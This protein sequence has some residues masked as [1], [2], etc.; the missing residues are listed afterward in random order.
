MKYLYISISAA[1]FHLSSF[2]FGQVVINV[3]A[4][5]LKKP[6]SPYIYGKNNSLSDNPA[7]PLNSAEWQR[8]HDMG[9]KMFRENGG[10]NATKYN[11]RRKLSSHPDWY[12][13]VY[14]H[15]WDFAASSLGTNIPSAQGMWAFQLIGKAARTST[16]NFND[17][18]F[19]QSKWWSGTGQNL[20]GGGQVDTSG[21]SDALVEGNPSLYLE[22]WNADSTTGI[23][24]HWFGASGPGLDSGKLVYWSMDNE[25][26]IWNGTHD[27]VWPSQPSAEEFMQMYFATAKKARAKFPGIKLVGPVPANEWQWYNWNGGKINYHG[28]E[29]VWLEYFILRVAEEQHTSGIRLL[30]VLDIHF[31]PYETSP[32]DITQLYRVFFDTTYNYP[33]ANGVKKLGTTITKEYIFKRCSDWLKQYMG[34]GH[35]VTFSVTETAIAKKDDPSLTA[36]WY[37]STLGEFAKQGVEVFTPWD[38][39]PG[40][41]EVIHLYTRYGK[42]NILPAESSNEYYVSA[43]PTITDGS[44]SMTV[45]LINRHL[46]ESKDISLR[47][48][49]FY[50]KDG[51]HNLYTLSDL[52][53]SETFVSHSSNAIST[54]N[55]EISDNEIMLNLPPLSVSALVVSKGTPSY[56]EMVTSAEA[57]TGSLVG[58]TTS[59][60]RAGYSGSGYVAGFD[61][62]GDRVTVNINVPVK[63][64]YRIVIR[65]SA[66]GLNNHN[67]TVNG[68]FTANLSFPPTDTFATKDA[69]GFVLNSGNN[70]ISLNHISGTLEPDKFEI[71]LM[72]TNDFDIAPRL[73]DSA[74]SQTTKVLYDYLQSQFGKKIISGQTHDYYSQLKNVAGKSPMLR[75][76]DF[77]HF[78][79]GYPYLWSNE[80]NGHIYGYDGNDGTVNS[81]INWYNASGK[82]GIVSMHWHWHDPL[83]DSTSNVS[84]NTFYTNQTS[85]DIRRAVI[86]GTLEYNCVIRDID[87]IAFQLKKFQTAGI[88]VLW[89]PL[90][91]AGGGWF[92]WGA[93]GAEPCLALWDMLIERLKNYHQLH[94]LIWIW[95]SPEPEWYPGNDKV[96]MIGYDSYPGSFNYTNQKSI[97][98][99]LFMITRGEKLIA[100]TENGPIPD[101]D[102][103]ITGDAPWL[104]FMSWSDLVV[105]QNSESHIRSVYNNPLVLSLESLAPP[106]FNVTIRVIRDLTYDPLNVNSVLFNNETKVTNSSGEVLYAV[107]PGTYEYFIQRTSYESIEGTIEVTSDTTITF[108]LHQTHANVRMRLR[109]DTRPV[110]NAIVSLDLDTLYSNSLGDA[111]YSQ[112]PVSTS[113]EYTITKDGYEEKEGDVYLS[114]DTTVLIQMTKATVSA[115]F[116]PSKSDF[117]LW[118][119]PARE[120][121]NISTPGQSNKRII[122]ITSLSG[123][124]V[125]RIEMDREQMQLDIRDL[126]PGAY[127]VQII[128]DDATH[129]GFFTKK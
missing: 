90:H 17:W 18:S 7:D 71:Y 74:A 14:S 83:G 1:F 24:D 25:P 9:I 123:L 2:I 104:Y 89:R 45:F 10:N 115:D 75:A 13:N 37:A 11:W 129:R 99:N 23:L 73:I 55:I 93:H 65:Y 86:P 81:L 48:D 19:N 60:T 96:D 8:L 100:M 36:N 44:D 82:K 76:G 6:I 69:G 63:D 110:T 32:S 117:R 94:N 31:Y 46:Y 15:N 126:I 61:T 68:A 97:F 39:I 107:D 72:Q 57:E 49:E 16:A 47:L 12:N 29:Y 35:G 34:T 22:N 98:D 103:S 118:P 52:P 50:V 85:F 64:V 113:Y 95:S 59:T 43:Y 30:D 77:Q 125:R 119:N 5:A 109:E 56:G 114:R 38:W 66:A 51:S 20:A 106:K 122:M 116:S 91:E 3:D 41:S 102:A 84:T 80:I 105:S 33:G 40:M 121:L 111:L 21:G 70:V 108:I 58:V 101:P 92:W 78:T 54:N 62:S 67:L 120:F 53:S 87:S 88:P 4:S 112:L 128:T 79:Q 124:T 42:K 27:D 26:E 28:Q 127:V